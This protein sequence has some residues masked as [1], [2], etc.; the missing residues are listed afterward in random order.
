MEKQ[1]IM[2]VL[3]EPFIYQHFVRHKSFPYSHEGF[4]GH[5]TAVLNVF[6]FW[7]H[8]QTKYVKQLKNAAIQEDEFEK[9]MA[10]EGYNIKSNPNNNN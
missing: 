4:L 1:V 2:D 5:E 10:E 6:T 9:Y 8:F 7:D 3:F